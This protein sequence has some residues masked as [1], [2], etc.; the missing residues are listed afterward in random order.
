[1]SKEIKEKLSL[2]HKGQIPWNKGKTGVYSED[3]L[4]RLS[5][6]HRGPKPWKRGKIPRGKLEILWQKGFGIKKG[7]HFSEE[8]RRR[9]SEVRRGMPSPM[10]GKKHSK[11]TKERIRQARMKQRIPTF[12]TKPE[13]K[14]LD[15][16]QK[17]NLSYKY[18]GDGAFWI[19][20]INPDFVNNNGE[21]I[22]IEVWGKYWHNREDNRKR[23]EE[24]LITLQKYGWK[25]IVFWDDEINELNVLNKLKM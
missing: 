14:M 24:K 7:D 16:I 1:M 5:L 23:D 11:E 17:Y 8:R 13:L 4:K 3:S 21:K 20:N 2:S 9:M 10:T 25:R 12:R 15:I 18:T 22:I 6:S 19:E